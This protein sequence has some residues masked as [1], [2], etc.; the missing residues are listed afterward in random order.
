MCRAFH[1]DFGSSPVIHDGKVVVL[2]DGQKDSFLAGFDL[3][4]GG[5]VWRTA[6]KDLPTWGTP[7]V[8]VSADRTQMVVNGWP[9]K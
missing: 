6:R 5:E 9:R 2:C 8:I 3:A 1:G 4:D 7:V